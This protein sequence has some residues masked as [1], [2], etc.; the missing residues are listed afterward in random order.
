MIA[1]YS[2]GLLDH[3]RITTYV[4]RLSFLTTLLAIL[5][6][7]FASGWFGVLLIILF[8]SYSAYLIMNALYYGLKC[9][10]KYAILG[11]L[12]IAV[13]SA[14]LFNFNGE[15]ISGEFSRPTQ[16]KLLTPEEEREKTQQAKEII[17]KLERERREKGL[18][19]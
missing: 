9:E 11:S 14:V 10:R 1:K 17:E 16:P 7:T 5:N 13:L 4:S 2:R 19:K 15:R 3:L 18:E 12:I 6:A 8:F